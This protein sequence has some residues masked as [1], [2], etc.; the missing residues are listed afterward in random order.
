[1]KENDQPGPRPKTSLGL[2]AALCAG[3]ALGTGAAEAVTIM[4]IGDSITT[5]AHVHDFSSAAYPESAYRNEPGGPPNNISSYREHLHDML[6]FESC[7]ADIE[8]VGA[9]RSE[10]RTPA[11]HEGHGGWH[12]AY[13]RELT[14]R[15][16]NDAVDGRRN[17]DGW[18]RALDP[19]V[20]T[21]HVGTN[22]LGR[23]RTA[24]QNT[25]NIE[26]ILDTVFAIDP[27]TR[28][29]L[30]NVI[31]I[32]GYWGDRATTLSGSMPT[33]REEEVVLTELINDL[34]SRQA[35]LGRNVVLVDVSSGYFVDEANP[36][37]CPTET[38]GNP[39]NMTLKVCVADPEGGAGT[40]PDGL[41][42]GLKG[43]RFVADQFFAAMRSSGGFCDSD[44]AFVSS[45]PIVPAV[46]PPSPI[47][48][49]DGL[50][51]DGFLDALRSWRHGR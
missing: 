19:D 14:W 40:I 49:P 29:F 23:T 43:D 24:A 7:N 34:A 39:E 13:F 30:A 48:N 17:L 47:A 6:T 3:V 28:V 1:M 8:W 9:R 31:P 5:G 37:A 38:G 18:L 16:A 33:V 11:V 4:P 41:H 20:I 10:G 15:D 45:T 12:A 27:T 21:L 50:P 51:I 26:E 32:A 22:G 25:D 42:P 44:P 35:A 36:V 2:C 46:L